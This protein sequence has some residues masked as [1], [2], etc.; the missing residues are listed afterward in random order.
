M[1]FVHFN[2]Y[3]V[4]RCG[5]RECEN[6]AHGE[7]QPDWLVNAIPMEN[8]KYAKCY[9]YALMNATTWNT[10]SNVDRCNE[11]LFDRS[12]VVPCAKDELIY[13]TDEISIENA[14]CLCE[15]EAIISHW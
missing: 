2:F 6:V 10:D 8:G 15:V 14:V 11:M 9:R 13:R 7:Y 3:W 12:K 5:I 1:N 4:F